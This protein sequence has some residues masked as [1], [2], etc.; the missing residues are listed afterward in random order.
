MTSLFSQ[1]TSTTHTLN[2]IAP[3]RVPDPSALLKSTPIKVKPPSEAFTG[4]NGMSP[5]PKS[6]PPLMETNNVTIKENSDHTQIQADGFF[7]KIKDE[8]H[9]EF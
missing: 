9:A 6:R 3:P 7:F 2:H 4:R 5:V 8:D 1:I